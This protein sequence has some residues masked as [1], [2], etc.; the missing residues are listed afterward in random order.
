MDATL[1][2]L[3]A[4]RVSTGAAERLTES[5]NVQ[6]PTGITPDGTQVAFFENTRTMGSDLMLLTLTP[7]R[8]VMDGSR[9]LGSV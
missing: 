3:A 5:A 7:P 1:H 2:A 6:V 9:K 4:V 8:R